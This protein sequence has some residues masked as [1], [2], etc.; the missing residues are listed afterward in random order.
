MHGCLKLEIPAVKRFYRGL[1]TSSLQNVNM[2]RSSRSFLNV[3]SDD[4]ICNSALIFP[5]STVVK[6]ASSL[7]PTFNRMF[8]R[9]M[10]LQGR[11]LEYYY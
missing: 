11:I 9:E 8:E 7:L 3:K 6:S 10:C 1:G 4:R 2:N 5:P